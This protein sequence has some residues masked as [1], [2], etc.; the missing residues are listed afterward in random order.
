MK[1]LNIIE[2]SNMLNT[3][4][5]VIYPNGD[6]RTINIETNV[7]G[8]LIDCDTGEVSKSFTDIINAKFIPIQ[9]PVSFNY[10]LKKGLEGKRIKF[11]VS[12]L[13][14]FKNSLIS[15]NNHYYNVKEIFEIFSMTTFLKEA[16][17]EGEWYV[18]E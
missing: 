14:E 6:K 13:D 16:I 9:Q 7:L 4:F 1:E 10:A 8:N 17:K 18:E 11:D 3:E 5:E 15:W 12:K 2:A